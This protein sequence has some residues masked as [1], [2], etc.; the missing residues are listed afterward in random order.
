[1]G[2]ANA[3]L[4]F[5]TPLVWGLGGPLPPASPDLPVLPP[6]PPGPMRLVRG[7]V[8]GRGA[9]E[10]RGPAC[11][12]NRVPVPK[13]VGQTPSA[14]L[15]LL[16][17]GPSHLPLQIPSFPPMP[18][19][20]TWPGGGFGLQ[21]TGLGGQQPPRAPVGRAI[22]LC[23]SSAPPGWPLPPATPD[24]PGL[25][26]MPPGPTWRGW[27]FG[28]GGS[29]LGAEQPPLP[30]QA[31]QSP[32]APLPLFP[33]SPSHLPLL[34]SLASGALILSGLHFSSPTQ[35]PYVLPVHFGVPPVSLGVRVPHQQLVGTVVVGRC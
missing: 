30:E 21:V 15:L 33:E 25:P 9:L 23:F 10:G 4:S 24:L 28:W 14:P 17:Q 27:G 31:R 6:I 16:P 3:L 13:W 1:M 2:A 29:G 18:P 35:S 19:G 5:P 26:P 20:P 7:E 8:R 32:S 11:E 12:L 22:P 34:I